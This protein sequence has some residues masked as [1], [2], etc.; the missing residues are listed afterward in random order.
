MLGD[1]SACPRFVRDRIGVPL[2]NLGPVQR[3]IGE[4]ASQL[5]S[6]TGTDRSAPGGC[7]ALPGLRPG[8]RVRDSEE[9]V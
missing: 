2:L 9:L 5:Q 3:F 8:D 6:L 7:A 1:G 4:K